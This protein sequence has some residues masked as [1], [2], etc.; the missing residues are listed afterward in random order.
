MLVHNPLDADLLFKNKKK[1][2]KLSKMNSEQVVIW[3][4]ITVECS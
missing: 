1:S 2:L 3:W 4:I